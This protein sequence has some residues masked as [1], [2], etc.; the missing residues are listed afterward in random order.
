M[1]LDWLKTGIVLFLIIF[2]L[3][4]VVYFQKPQKGDSPVTVTLAHDKGNLPVFQENF[5]LQGEKAKA[6]IGIGI[7]PIPSETTDLYRHQMMATL[8]TEQAPD[9]FI[10]WAT[11]RVKELVDSNFVGDIT[12]LWDKYKDDYSKGM[13]DAF[14][15]GDK[16][17]GFP[18]VVEYWPVW[19]NKSIFARLGLEPPKTWKEFIRV[20][21]VLKSSGVTPILSSLQTEWPAFIWFEEMIIGQDPQLYKDLCLGKAKYTDPRV[22]AAF[23]VWQDMIKRGFFTDPSVNMLTNAG[24]LWNN[25]QFGMVLCGTWYYSAVLTAQGVDEK[26]IGTFILP[27]HNPDAGKNII[28]EVGPIFNAK[29]AENADAAKKVLDWWM[30]REGN[31][32]FAKLHNAYPGNLKT[33][34]DYLPPVKKQLLQTIKDDNYQVLNRYWEAT[35]TPICEKAVRKFGEFIL[36]PD[37]LEQI[38]QDIDVIADE[39]WAAHS[40][41]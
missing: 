20:C 34:I 3:A 39:Y 2:L 19:Y 5:T 10:W 7:N 28:F 32:H 35:P 36:N 30:G 8:P 6:S 38:L 41:R 31:G 1:K 24:Y 13:R 15:I 25:E 9:L 16:V 17:Y 23:K 4:G 26:N 18:Y 12:D 33:D 21:E 37:S 29:N 40:N 27:S 14:T 22:V 11:F